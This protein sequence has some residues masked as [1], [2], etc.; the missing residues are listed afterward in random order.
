[1]ETCCGSVI[2]ISSRILIVGLSFLWVLV[3]GLLGRFMI[4]LN[5]HLLLLFLIELLVD[6]IGENYSIYLWHLGIALRHSGWQ[7][8]LL[9]LESECVNHMPLGLSTRCA[10]FPGVSRL[11]MCRRLLPS[12][13][14]CLLNHALWSCNTSA[15]SLILECVF[16][17]LVDRVRRGV[18]SRLWDVGEE[19]GLFQDGITNI[20]IKWWFLRR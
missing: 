19:V 15:C 11:K 20:G 3:L 17:F 9:A 13:V 16:L 18:T 7:I 8:I 12:F 10:C 14:L 2:S 4:M 6:L 5:I 1:M